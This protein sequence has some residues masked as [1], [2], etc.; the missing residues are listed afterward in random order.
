MCTCVICMYSTVL[1]ELDSLN[2]TQTLGLT[3]D[4]VEMQTFALYCDK[5]FKRNYECLYFVTK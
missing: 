4:T 5:L 1:L 3:L 2:F